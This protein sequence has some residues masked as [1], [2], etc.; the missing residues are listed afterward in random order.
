[1]QMQ[2]MAMGDIH[3]YAWRAVHRNQTVYLRKQEEERFGNW[4]AE[5]CDVSGNTSSTAPNV[6][7]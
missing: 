5:M 4:T 1:M 7:E 3:H 2:T 6:I